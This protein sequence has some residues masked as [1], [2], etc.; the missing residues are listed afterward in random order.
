M[1]ATSKRYKIVKVDDNEPPIKHDEI[2]AD[3]YEAML[4]VNYFEFLQY[5]LKSMNIEG[6]LQLE[7]LLRI[8]ADNHDKWSAARSMA[9][10]GHLLD[11]LEWAAWVIRQRYLAVDD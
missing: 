3:E 6:A 7:G 4:A 5:K 11:R 9:G 2:N 1:E 10:I 8:D